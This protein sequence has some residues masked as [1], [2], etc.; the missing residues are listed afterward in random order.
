MDLGEFEFFCVDGERLS[1]GEFDER[2][3]CVG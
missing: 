2:C 3:D 1:V